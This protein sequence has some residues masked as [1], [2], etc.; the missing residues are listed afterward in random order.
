MTDRSNKIDHYATGIPAMDDLTGGGLMEG[1]T[2][3]AGS[4]GIGKTSFALQIAHHAAEKGMPILYFIGDMFVKTLKA[5]MVSREMFTLA[6]SIEVCRSAVE[7]QMPD[8]EENLSRYEK[9]LLTRA[10]GRV[11]KDRIVF[12]EAAMK[13]P[14]V[15]DFVLL[16]DTF[17]HDAEIPPLIVIDSFSDLLAPWNVE[18]REKK[19]YVLHC[20]KEMAFR[21]KVPVLLL[22]D[23]PGE[24]RD[25]RVSLQ[26]FEEAYPTILS[27]CDDIFFLEM[28]EGGDPLRNMWDINLV[29]LRTMGVENMAEQTLKFYPGYSAF[30]MED[31][32]S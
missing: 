26:E 22:M 2:C 9:E 27:C 32:L 10:R 1:V 3:V 19:Q 4:S 18:K 11:A 24:M 28:A 16:T 30:R 8:L 15:D 7:L 13:S 31:V 29:G 6:D 20:L 14:T 17:C 5:K 21:N 12:V 23:M 25:R